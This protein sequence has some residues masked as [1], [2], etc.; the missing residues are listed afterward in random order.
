[1]TER[2]SENQAENEVAL[3]V[4]DVHR[5][6]TAGALTVPVL[7]GVDLDILR[8]ELTVIVGH[9]GS[10]KTTLLNVMGALDLPTSGKILFG[11]LDLAQSAEKR[12]TRFRREHTGFVFQLYNLVPT[13]TASENIE[14]AVEGAPDAM[15][16][17]EALERVGLGDRGDSF[18][19]ELSG[20]EQQRVAVARA[21][22]R[23]PALLL[24]DE[25]TGALD[26]A[27]GRKILDLV[28]DLNRDL[29]MTIVVITHAS[30]IA[31]LAHQVVRIDSGVITE[32]RRNE[33]RKT[34]A[35]IDW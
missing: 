17:L 33:V 20:G 13:L 16:A 11:D 27:T 22:A 14:V 19:S 23:R 8:G 1:M 26:S 10:G 31:D 7:R 4:V 30:P 12:R 18:P 21:I 5:S 3:R 24:C 25:L 2:P 32:R 28:V 15:T 29:G 6:F 35:E 9:S 34:V